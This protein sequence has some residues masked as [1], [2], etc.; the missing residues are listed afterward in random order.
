MTATE[1]EVH[2]KFVELYHSEPLMVRS[3]GRINLI[4]EHTDYNNGF[5]MPA[6]IDKEIIFA[7]G[8]SSDNRSQIHAVKYNESFDVDIQDALRVDSPGWVNYQLGVLKQFLMKG[9]KI[10][11]FHCVFSGDVPLGAGLSSSAAV[12]CGFAFALN[13]LFQCNESRMSMVHMSQW[14]E[15]NYAGVRC[16]IMDQFASMMGRAGHVMMLDCRSLEYKY[17]PFHAENYKLVLFDSKVKHSLVDSEYNARRQ[18]CELGVQILKKHYPAI[19]S[20][21]DVSPGQVS[22]HKHELHGKVFQRCLYVTQEIARV[23]AAA[24]DLFQRDWAAFGRKMFET[25]DGL[26]KLYEVSCPELDFLVAEVRGNQGVLGA[27]MMGGGFGGCTIN[28]VREDVLPA[29]LARVS[30]A[31]YQRFG[32]SSPHYVVTLCDGSTSLP[33][34]SAVL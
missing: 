27:R 21:R 9:H 26:S 28:I 23:K 12:E 19:T 2:K 17:V 34:R 1:K 22:T 11:H 14:A 31:Y 10:G 5:V 15:H 6:A 25:H 24:E 20:L 16:G 30:E 7:I 29:V 33:V 13:E 32:K 3:P 8:K 18:E 4:G